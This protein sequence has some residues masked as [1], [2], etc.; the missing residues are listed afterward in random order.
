MNVVYPQTC[1]LDGHKK[2]V[3]ACVLLTNASGHIERQVR[4]FTTMINDLLQLAAWLT[5]LNVTHIALESTGVY[6]RPVFNIL[7]DD[8]RTLVL[9]NA[10][11][12]KTVPGRKTDLKDTE[13]LADLL[14]HGLLKASFIVTVCRRHCPTLSPAL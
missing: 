14:R 13:W 10:Q 1:G 9:V 7:E 12:L 2:M 4:T 11:H 5:S 8:R 6:W 3:V